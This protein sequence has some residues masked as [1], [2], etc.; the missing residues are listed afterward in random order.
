M[1]KKRI[2]FAV[3][4][5][6]AAVLLLFVYM[7]QKEKQVFGG[8]GVEVL[9]AA[10]D[11]PRETPIQAGNLAIRKVPSGFVHPHAIYPDSRD[12]I[13]GQPARYTLLKGQPILWSDIGKGEGGFSAALNPGE[14][15]MAIAV[16]EIT[17]IAGSLK[18]ND[19]VD[20][21][22]TFESGGRTITKVILQNVTVIGVGTK[23]SSSEN[24]DEAE[25]NM[26]GSM[27]QGAYSSVTVAVTPEEAEML[28][29]AQERG[30]LA[31]VLRNPADLDVKEN[32]PEV[33]LGSILETE[34]RLNAQRKERQ[35]ERT[36]II[37]GGVAEQNQ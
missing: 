6:A 30:K 18:P 17:G 29:L 15:A 1:E 27:L 31:L 21:L 10:S 7:Q 16:D 9:V 14:R 2:W 26:I 12:V 5:A 11:I 33:S 35:V 24:K 25:M 28:V 36:E 23:V 3:I 37:K 34:R 20:V 4:I 13:L 19:R 8:S 32:L 22:G